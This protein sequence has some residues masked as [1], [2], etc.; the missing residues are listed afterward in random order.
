MDILFEEDMRSTSLKENTKML[1][2]Q[3]KNLR[4]PKCDHA[5]SHVFWIQ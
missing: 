4:T 1:L 2:T 5:F 3:N